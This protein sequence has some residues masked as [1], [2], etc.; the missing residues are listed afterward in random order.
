MER[1]EK[2]RSIASDLI[3]KYPEFPDGYYLMAICEYHVGRIDNSIELCQNALKYGISPFTVYVAMMFYY[4]E[5]GDYD[6]VEQ[7]Y[8]Q[9]SNVYSKD[10]DARAL[11][12]F[13]LWKRGKKEE[14][15][16]MMEEAFSKD[17][18]NTI[19]LQCLLHACKKR[20]KDYLRELVGIYMNTKA[21]E[22]NKLLFAGKAEAYLGNWRK[23]KK[24]FEKVLSI[25]PTNKEAK[26]FLKLIKM[27]RCVVNIGICV[28]LAAVFCF[29][30]YDKM[31]LK[32]LGLFLILLYFAIV[33]TMHVLRKNPLL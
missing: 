6:S 23:A 20:G 17:Y 12:G 2:A 28:T 32:V 33:G 4:I 25:D 18:T 19:V 13:S 11:Y 7:C 21:S 1:F 9:I 14:G 26:G 15:I 27:E 8:N 29:F 30:V 5:K 22:K 24:I 3:S 10:A 31:I 16:R